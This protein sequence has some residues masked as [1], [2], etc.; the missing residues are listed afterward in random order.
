MTILIPVVGIL[1]TTLFLLLWYPKQIKTGR[2]AALYTVDSA[3]S[4][5]SLDPKS[6]EYKLL[7]SGLNLKP[8]TFRL[9]R[10]A[11]GVCGMVIAW[12]FLPGLPAIVIGGILFYV[13]G[14]WLDDRVK[15]RGRNIDQLLPIAIG[16][17]AAGLLAGGSVPD[18]LQQVG[19]SLELEKTN[20]LT[21]EFVLTASEMRIKDRVEALRSLASR[22]PSVSL[23]NLAQLLEGYTESGGRAYTGIL[24]DISSRVQQILIARN[25][26][27][28]KAGDSLVSAKVLPV[29]LIFILIYLSQDPMVRSSLIALPV[30]IVIGVTM[31]AMVGGY[32]IIRS[33]IMEAV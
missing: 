10:I 4:L 20:P 30:Q 24:M 28:A 1:C 33:M 29:V 14:A 6:L 31:A 11:S 18:V 15:S 32:F 3:R 7:A 12:L 27:Q 19:E 2:L 16:R 25:R 23:S 26:A 8:I 5:S 17:T 22:S 13:P 21:P 9:L